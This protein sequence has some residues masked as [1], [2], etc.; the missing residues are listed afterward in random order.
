MLA[1][2]EFGSSEGYI[3]VFILHQRN[4]RK[5]LGFEL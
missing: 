2:V 5:N 3:I 1:A 4:T